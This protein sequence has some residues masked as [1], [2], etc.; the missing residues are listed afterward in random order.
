MTRRPLPTAP[1]AGTTHARAERAKE[2]AA[3]RETGASENGKPVALY[4]GAA[5]VLASRQGP[6]RMVAGEEE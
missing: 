5:V 6:A 3:G 4:S 1:P 2:E